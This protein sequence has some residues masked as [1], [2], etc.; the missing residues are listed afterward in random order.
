MKELLQ[1]LRELEKIIK[2]DNN[3]FKEMKKLQDK[4]RRNLDEWEWE[5]DMV[6]KTLKKRHHLQEMAAGLLV[7][8]EFYENH[9]KLHEIMNELFQEGGLVDQLE[10]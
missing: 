3:F 2:F 7:E 10:Q 9:A 6:L 5:T 1:K 8:A 4:N